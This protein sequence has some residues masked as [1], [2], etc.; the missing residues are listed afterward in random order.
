MTD[1]VYE[2]F[3][4]DFLHAFQKHLELFEKEFLKTFQK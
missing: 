1:S 3:S 4:S 2:A